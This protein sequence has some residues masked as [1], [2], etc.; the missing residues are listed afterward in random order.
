MFLIKNV[1]LSPNNILEGV[2]FESGG[3]FK[4]RCLKGL[5]Y[6]GVNWN[7]K[8][9]GRR[10]SSW[11]MNHNSSLS[12]LTYNVNFNTI[13]GLRLNYCLHSKGDPELF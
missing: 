3:I 13:S 11:E 1:H 10:G 12:T 5:I 6:E 4:G 9:Y 8:V 7:T 2:V